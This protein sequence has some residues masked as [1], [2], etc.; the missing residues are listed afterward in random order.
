MSLNLEQRLDVLHEVE[1]FVAGRRPEIVA[2]N[3]KARLILL[4]FLVD[5]GHARLLAEWRIR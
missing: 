2:N 3:D 1:L 5:H 4:S